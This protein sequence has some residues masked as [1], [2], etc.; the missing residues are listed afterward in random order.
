MSG[1]ISYYGLFMFIIFS[2]TLPDVSLSQNLNK[3]IT[4]VEYVAKING[5]STDASLY[6]FD[7]LTL[8]QWFVFEE[9]EIQE[10]FNKDN[11]SFDI[12]IHRKDGFFVCKDFKK[13]EMLSKESSILK[14]Y[15]VSDVLPDIN[16]EILDS[17]KI[18]GGYVSKK[19]K[20]HFRGRNYK[21]W[22]TP[23]IP[24]SGGPWKLGGLPGLILEVS[25]EENKVEIIL[26][27]IIS[28]ESNEKVT[29]ICQNEKKEI[30]QWNEYILE[31]NNEI[32]QLKQSIENAN[33]HVKIEP[34]FSLEKHDFL[35]GK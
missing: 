33:R 34:E 32:K 15:Y 2:S 19:A 4:K 17:T 22:F 35:N 6:L 5:E 29:D 3:Y 18:I 23:E 31:F 30:F 28:H 24:L 1:R 11:L 13:N 12:S 7:D 8:F 16:W 27:D 14:Y 9:N 21:V 26:E 10:S 25:D 20:G